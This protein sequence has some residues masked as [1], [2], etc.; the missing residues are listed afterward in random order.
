MV[1]GGVFLR[2]RVKERTHLDTYEAP[3]TYGEAFCG[4]LV[5]NSGPSDVPQS[6]PG[7]Q[8]TLE[9]VCCFQMGTAASLATTALKSLTLGKL[10]SAPCFED[11][12]QDLNPAE[13]VEG[14][15]SLANCMSFSAF[16]LS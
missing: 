2:S 1:I 15:Q 7:G 9:Q 3:R 12:K 11:P 14:C 6:L 8:Y 4:V 5:L 10:P 16:F 13:T